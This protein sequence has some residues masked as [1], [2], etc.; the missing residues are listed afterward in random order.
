MSHNI[1]G[2]VGFEAPELDNNYV[3]NLPETIHCTLFR[4]RE[5]R[6]QHSF[7]ETYVTSAA[8]DCPVCLFVCQGLGFFLFSKQKKKGGGWWTI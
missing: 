8:V 2:S 4:E 1:I 5:K 6:R 3:L 7:T